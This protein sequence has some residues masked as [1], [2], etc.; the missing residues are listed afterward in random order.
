MGYV[1]SGC[2][3]RLEEPIVELIWWTQSLL[4]WYTKR[5]IRS[6]IVNWICL[7]LK[8][9]CELTLFAQIVKFSWSAGRGTRALDSGGTSKKVPS[10]SNPGDKAYYLGAQILWIES[11]MVSP[12]KGQMQDKMSWQFSSQSSFEYFL[13]CMNFVKINKLGRFNRESSGIWRGACYASAF[14][15]SIR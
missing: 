13:L 15:D 11:T 5:E 12:F 4:S 1:C 9:D 14:I 8:L 10:T 7:E 3:N 6:F 2:Q